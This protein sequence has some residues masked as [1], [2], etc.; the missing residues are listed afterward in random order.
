MGK[1]N[2]YKQRSMMAL[3]VSLWMA[4][5]SDDAYITTL[6][7]IA[8]INYEKDF[9]FPKTIGILLCKWYQLQRIFLRW[10][11]MALSP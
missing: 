6:E 8:N 10:D 4:I 5:V 1:K 3:G 2:D 9:L 11:Q 7:V